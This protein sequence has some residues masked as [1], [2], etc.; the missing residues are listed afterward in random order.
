MINGPYNLIRSITGSIY[1]YQALFLA[2][3]RITARPSDTFLPEAH[4]TKEFSHTYTNE[5]EWIFC[6]DLVLILKIAI[7]RVRVDMLHFEMTTLCHNHY[8]SK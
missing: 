6:F 8:E 5:M 4:L 7:M 1:V 2:A 3:Q